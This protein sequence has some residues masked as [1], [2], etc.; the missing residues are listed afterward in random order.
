MNAK[1]KNFLFSGLVAGSLMASAAPAMARD[2]WHWNNNRWDR[3]ADIRSDQQD[4]AQARRQLAYDRSHRASR[5]TIAVD[6][7][8][9][10]DLERDLREDRR[11]SQR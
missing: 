11:L 1:V 10:R 7:A 5:H 3:R 8:R 9:I 2:Y 6:E 4:L